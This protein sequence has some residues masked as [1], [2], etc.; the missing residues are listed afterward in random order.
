MAIEVNSPEFGEKVLAA[1]RE[2]TIVVDFW[3]A[4]CAPC[5]MLAP[6]LEKVVGDLAPHAE[7]VKVNV[8]QNPDL[9][10]NFG[11]R[12]IP[13]VRIFRDGVEVGGFVGV[14][15]ESE[16]RRII[17]R[18]VYTRSD[19]LISA[20]VQMVAEGRAEEAEQCL[21]EALE[22]EPDYPPALLELARLYAEKGRME[23][24]RSLLQKIPRISEQWAEA[25]QLLAKISLE[26]SG[27][28]SED[29]AE[30]ERQ[31]AQ[32]KSAELWYRAGCSRAARGEYREALEDL[33]HS[34]EIDPHWNEDAA[35]NKMLQIFQVIGVRSPLA[36]EYR[37][38]LQRLLF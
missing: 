25:E 18:H 4:W 2:K 21:K 38:K 3:A 32:K 35:R 10:A 33:L 37:D 34:A 28:E 19:K 17:R 26:K 11:I 6:I 1:S 12:G 29:P 9:A 27:A 7:L 23:E 15:P 13:A 20:A 22:V 16:V 30:L 5:H 24:A 36:D 8:D 14:L 31:A